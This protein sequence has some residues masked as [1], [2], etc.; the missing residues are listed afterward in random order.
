MQAV[1]WQPIGRAHT[2]TTAAAASAPF[3]GSELSADSAL[4]ALQRWGFLWL[5]LTLHFK[6]LD[7]CRHEGLQWGTGEGP[8]LPQSIGWSKTVNVDCPA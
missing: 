7:P 1:K 5:F 2:S 6:P 8:S 4:A 3:W